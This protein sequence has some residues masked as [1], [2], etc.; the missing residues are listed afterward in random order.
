MTRGQAIARG[1][2]HVQGR[3]SVRSRVEDDSRERCTVRRGPGK[4]RLKCRS[5]LGLTGRGRLEPPGQAGPGHGS[6]WHPKSEAAGP[7]AS[8]HES[9][10]VAEM[11]MVSRLGPLVARPVPAAAGGD[12]SPTTP[13]DPSQLKKQ[14]TLEPPSK[15]SPARAPGP[16]E[17]SFIGSAPTPGGQARRHM[18]RAALPRGGAGW[19]R[20]REFRLWQAEAKFRA[21]ARITAPDR[22]HPQPLADTRGSST[23]RAF[24][25][26]QRAGHDGAGRRDGVRQSGQER[27]RAGEKQ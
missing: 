1:D 10:G 20:R 3:C 23:G 14:P 15:T 25:V 8:G 18:K 5:P 16:R 7:G 13:S 9:R 11:A 6:A 2:G 19:I 24:V 4:T 12:E 22:C 27:A 26:A 21:G 17:D